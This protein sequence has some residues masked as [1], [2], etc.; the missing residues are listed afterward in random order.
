ML[1]NLS[2]NFTQLSWSSACTDRSVT[3]DLASGFLLMCLGR[4]TSTAGAAMPQQIHQPMHTMNTSYKQHVNS[5]CSCTLN[6]KARTDCNLQTTVHVR[7]GH[8]QEVNRTHEACS[9]RQDDSIVKGCT[10]ARLVCWLLLAACGLWSRWP[11]PA[12]S[13][14]EWPDWIV[15]HLWS[16]FRCCHIQDIHMYLWYMNIIYK[17]VYIWCVSWICK[18]KDLSGSIYH[19]FNAYEK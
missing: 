1:P 14:A 9:C 5:L 8:P 11:C 17:Y 7:Y 2:Q 12:H 3:S 19:L 4:Q 15:L 6:D 16:H 18:L 10:C 13:A